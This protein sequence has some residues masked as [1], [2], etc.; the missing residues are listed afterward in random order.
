MFLYI[1]HISVRALPVSRYVIS[2][3]T[4]EHRKSNKWA[5]KFKLE[6]LT[7]QRPKK[8]S[9]ASTTP[10]RPH[11][12]RMRNIWTNKK[13]DNQSE[14]PQSDIQHQ[15]NEQWNLAAGSGHIGAA[16]SALAEL[17]CPMYKNILEHFRTF[18]NK[19]I[20]YVEFRLFKLFLHKNTK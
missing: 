7:N 1:G 16:A 17:L 20:L 18:Y 2:E 11:W 15:T 8:W 4:L 12:S 5:M 14:A 13:T 19:N 6:K 3:A 9:D 10:E